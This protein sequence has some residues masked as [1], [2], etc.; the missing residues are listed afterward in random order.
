M[1]SYLRRRRMEL[2]IGQGDDQ[3]EEERVTGCACFSTSGEEEKQEQPARRQASGGP[4]RV[5]AMESRIPSS[6]SKS[7]L[8]LAPARC[9]S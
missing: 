8:N 3:R 5:S 1:R 6:S 4:L 9:S 7:R 2:R